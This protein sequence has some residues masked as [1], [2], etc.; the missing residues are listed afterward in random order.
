MESSLSTSLHATDAMFQSV[1]PGL[2]YLVESDT[3]TPSIEC[4]LKRTNAEAGLGAV[5]IQSGTHGQWV[6]AE[7]CY[8]D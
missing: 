5:G 1:Q 2:V 7:A 3:A 6:L 4:S 8:V